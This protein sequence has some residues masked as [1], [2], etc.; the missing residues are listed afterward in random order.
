MLSIMA[1]QTDPRHRWQEAVFWQNTNGGDGAVAV[2]RSMTRTR[3]KTIGRRQDSRQ[4]WLQ[5]WGL[6]MVLLVHLSLDGALG[7]FPNGSQVL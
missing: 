5:T 7:D 4:L 3:F 1:R 6:K 2:Q